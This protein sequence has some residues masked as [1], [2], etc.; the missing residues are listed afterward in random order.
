MKQIITLLV[1]LLLGQEGLRAAEDFRERVY[2]QTDK[3]VYLAGELLWLKLCLTDASG[4][5]ASFS[6]VG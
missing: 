5:P 3:Q 2:A 6:K 4:V 1:A